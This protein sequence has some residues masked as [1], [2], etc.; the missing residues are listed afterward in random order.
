MAL[1]DTRSHQAPLAT[2]PPTR[3]I[4]L[5][6]DVPAQEHPAQQK[7][8]AGLHAQAN[9]RRHGDLPV[10]VLQRG[11]E[12]LDVTPSSTAARMPSMGRRAAL[13]D[14]PS[15]ATDRPKPR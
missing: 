10:G 8:E 1:R 7:D 13:A 5:D 12:S 11:W 6:G 3:G 14:P 2:A 4:D 9:Q 15:T